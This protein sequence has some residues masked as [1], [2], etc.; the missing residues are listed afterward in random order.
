MKTPFT[1][2]TFIFTH[3]KII[4]NIAAIVILLAP[5]I[6]VVASHGIQAGS[7][8]FGHQILAHDIVMEEGMNQLLNNYPAKWLDAIAI[9]I[10]IASA[11]SVMYLIIEAIIW[12]N[13]KTGEF[14]PWKGLVISILILAFIEIFYMFYAQLPFRWPFQ[15]LFTVLVHPLTFLRPVFPFLEFA[16]SLSLGGPSLPSNFSIQ[17][18]T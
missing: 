14:I 4:T 16:N 11:L 9:W 8:E 2:I 12:I 5:V 13:A 7:L 15:G 3:L 17:N 6:Q 18:G 1:L 10:R